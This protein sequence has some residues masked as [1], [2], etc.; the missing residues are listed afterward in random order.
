MEYI[1]RS[2]FTFLVLFLCLSGCSTNDSPNGS[3]IN[4]DTQ[5]LDLRE[6]NVTAVKFDPTSSRFDVTLFHDDD[7]EAGYA[8]WWQVE[9]LD[10]TIL[11]RRELTHAHGTQEFTR[12]AFITVPDGIDYIVIRGHDQTHDYGGQ[13]IVYE[14]NTGTEDKI[15]QGSEQVDFR[16][17]PNIAI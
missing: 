1:I 4:A 9:L 14:I 10:G 12:S 17:Y 16:D 7:G 6:A 8:D 11:G 3:S 2:L 13:A 15:R 5:D